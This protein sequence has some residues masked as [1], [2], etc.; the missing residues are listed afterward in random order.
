M[1]EFEVLAEWRIY[2]IKP[3]TTGSEEEIR[4]W[5]L[6]SLGLDDLEFKIYDYICSKNTVTVEDIVSK[7]ELEEENAREILDK[8]YTIGLVEKI[9]KAYYIKYPLREALIKK[10]LPRVM[11]VLK[12]IAKVYSSRNVWFF[13]KSVRGKSFNSVRE[14]IPYIKYLKAVSVP[15]VRIIGSHVY[16]G[17]IVEFEGIVDDIDL[18]NHSITVISNMGEEVEVGD[19]DS[20]GIDVEASTIIIEKGGEIE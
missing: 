5:A 8:L 14:A 13:S 16:S 7:F 3:P 18:E 1:Q 10:T 17:D 15:K 4:K 12:T 19:F 6:K 9:G 20:K 11:E 2:R